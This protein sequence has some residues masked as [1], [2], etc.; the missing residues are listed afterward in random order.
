LLAG[1]VIVIESRGRLYTKAGPS[2]RFQEP[3]LRHPLGFIGITDVTFVH[4]EKVGYGRKHRVAGAA[5]AKISE[6][7]RGMVKAA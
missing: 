4:A 1:S 6:V 5:K 7:G 3:Y 2:R